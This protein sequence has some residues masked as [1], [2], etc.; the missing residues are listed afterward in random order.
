[1]ENYIQFYYNAAQV[2]SLFLAA[3]F[4]SRVVQV[5]VTKGIWKVLLVRI[6]PYFYADHFVQKGS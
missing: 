5:I 2:S 1:M 6:T 3:C 4:F